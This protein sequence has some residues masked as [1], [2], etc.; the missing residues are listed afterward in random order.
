MIQLHTIHIAILR[1]NKEVIFIWAS[2]HADILG[3]VQADQD[4]KV[5]Y[6]SS[7]QV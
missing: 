1:C 4:A 7:A 5:A 6:Q 2:G 3:N